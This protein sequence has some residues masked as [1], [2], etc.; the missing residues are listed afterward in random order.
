MVVFV[1]GHCNESLRKKAV[2]AHF[3]L[4]RGCVT[5]S[6]IDCQL[7]FDK[8]SYKTHCSCMS[9][10][11]KYDKKGSCLKRPGPSKQEQWTAMVR[12]T[13]S[14]CDVKD[15]ETRS[16]LHDLERCPNLPRKKSKFENFMKSKYRHLNL[17]KIQ[18][19]WNVISKCFEEEKSNDAKEAKQMRVDSDTKS[20]NLVAASDAENCIEV[21]GGSIKLRDLLAQL[22]IQYSSNGWSGSKKIIKLALMQWIQS[23]E[24]SVSY[25]AED[26]SVSLIRHEDT[27]NN[28]CGEREIGATVQG[29]SDGIS[30]F[31]GLILSILSD[32]SKHQLP[33]KK[34]RKRVVSLY[35][36]TLGLT[37]PLTREELYARLDRKLRK[38][39]L[40]HLDEDGK[41]VHLIASL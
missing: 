35:D 19:I 13:I 9:E 39:S 36:S 10:A 6:C 31:S 11:Q 25:S 8:S 5:V 26:N 41:T 24:H 14:N 40:F 1:C 37:K 3:M 29:N 38:S 28:R 23:A 15:S 21:A 2:E 7:Q 22:L 17:E 20:A 16:F 18:D 30:S 27:I 4:C 12:R 33:L 34:L 32:S